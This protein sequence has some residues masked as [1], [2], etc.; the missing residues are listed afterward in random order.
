MPMFFYLPIILARSL[1]D[2]GAAVL[3]VSE[4]PMP[5][6]KQRRTQ[7]GFDEPWLGARHPDRR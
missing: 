1:A 6:A 2:V 4:A 7:P 3:R 5:V